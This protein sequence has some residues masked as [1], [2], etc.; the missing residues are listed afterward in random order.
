MDYLYTHLVIMRGDYWGI[1]GVTSAQGQLSTTELHLFF[2]AG[3]KFQF[4]VQVEG[5]TG[6]EIDS[7]KKFPYTGEDGIQK[8]RQWIIGLPDNSQC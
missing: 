6:M 1:S 7:I 3:C 2:G 4:V 5:F 8:M